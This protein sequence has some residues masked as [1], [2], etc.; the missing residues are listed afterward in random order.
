MLVQLDRPLNSV[1]LARLNA[2]PETPGMLTVS[3]D[4]GNG[5]GGGSDGGNKGNGVGNGGGNGTDS[6]GGK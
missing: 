6:E 2:N 4:I 3:K 1:P 5:G